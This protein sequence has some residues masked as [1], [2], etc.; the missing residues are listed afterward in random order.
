MK[1]LRDTS[2]W[3]GKFPMET[4]GMEQ[5][6]GPQCFPQVREAARRSANSAKKVSHDDDASIALPEP[7]RKRRARGTRA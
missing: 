3:L 7:A 2:D 6:A 4:N 5:Y 1:A